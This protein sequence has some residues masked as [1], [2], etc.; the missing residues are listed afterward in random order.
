MELI[1]IGVNLTN[2]A[3]ARDRRE[4]LDR[5]KNAGVAALLVTGTDLPSSESALALSME[6]PGYCYA[7][8]GVHP[9]HAK[10]WSADTSGHLTALAGRETVLALGECGLDFNRNFSPPAAQEAAFEEQLA[11]AAQLGMP[12]FLHQRDAHARFLAIIRSFR[13]RIPAAV[14]HCFTGSRDELRNYLDLDLHIGIT[15]WICDE[16][17]GQPL[18]EAVAGIPGERLMIETDAPYLIPRTMPKRPSDGRNEPA[19]LPYV[20]DTLARCRNASPADTAAITTSTAR[21]FFGLAEG[22]DANGERRVGG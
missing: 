22:R 5:A 10:H 15:G 18:R 12:I 16:R 4:V 14:V 1:D 11:L 6:N 7:T 9:H 3:F 21:R 17:R 20:L 8:A 13:D 2:R 19:F